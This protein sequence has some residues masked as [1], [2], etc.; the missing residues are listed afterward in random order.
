MEENRFKR[1]RYYDKECLHQK[2]SM[3]KLADKMEISKATISKLE[4][5]D[6]YDARISIIKKYKEQFPDITFD[7]LLGAT[8]TQHK[9]YNAIEEN[10]PFENEFYDNLEKLLATTNIH[11]NTWIHC[12]HDVYSGEDLTRD[13]LETL[14]NAFIKDSDAL[15]T[16][17]LKTFQSMLSLYKIKYEPDSISHHFDTPIEYENAANFGIS[18]AYLN[19]VKDSLMVTLEPYLKHCVEQPKNIGSMD[20]PDNID[21]PF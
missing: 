8:N 21:L 16:L 3:T 14:F 9:Q 17:L 15:H 20:I 5:Q 18:Q 4:A 1:L 19:F 2:I 7:Y 11:D 13:E 10:L 6:D 12:P